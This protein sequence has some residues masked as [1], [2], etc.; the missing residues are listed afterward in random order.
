M[1]STLKVKLLKYGLLCII[2]I[3]MVGIE[4]A[5]L[6]IGDEFSPET[7]RAFLSTM[8]NILETKNTYILGEETSSLRADNK[9]HSIYNNKIGENKYYLEVQVKGP[10]TF[11]LLKS[12]PESIRIQVELNEDLNIK[13]FYITRST[14]IWRVIIIPAVLIVFMYSLSICVL[15]RKSSPQKIQ[16]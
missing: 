9:K 15:I 5:I 2:T 7:E 1:E 11:L 3:I 8:N 13:S 12:I 14:F 10:K 6:A 16:K 4:I